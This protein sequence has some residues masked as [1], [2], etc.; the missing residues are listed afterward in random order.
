MALV[1]HCFTILLTIPYALE[2]SVMNGVG[3]WG[4]PISL[5]AKYNSSPLHMFT[6]SAPIST[7]AVL[8]ITFC[9]TLQT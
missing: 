4:W 7:S 5:R 8:D 2:L 1:Q 6:Y 9:M 3:G